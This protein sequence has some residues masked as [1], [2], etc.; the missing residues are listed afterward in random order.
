MSYNSCIAQVANNKQ[1]SFDLMKAIFDFK[2]AN[3]FRDLKAQDLKKIIQKT[4]FRVQTSI[5]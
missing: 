3:K 2:T 5:F 4:N 1:T